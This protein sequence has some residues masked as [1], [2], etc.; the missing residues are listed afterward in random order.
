MMNKLVFRN[1]KRSAKDYMVYFITMTVVTALMFSFNTLLFS[2]DIQK[3]FEMGADIMPIMIGLATFF[4]I[5]IVAWLINYMVRFT[6]EKRSREFGIYLLIGM[7]KKEISRLYIRENL[8]LG[9]GAFIIGM[10]SGFLLQQILLSIFYSMVQMDYHLHLEFNKNCILMTAACYGGCYLLALLRCRKRFKKMNIHDLMVSQ[11]Q[12]EEIKEKHE[13]GKQR[14]FPIS[15]VFLISFGIFLFRCKNWDTGTVVVF[16]IGLVLTVYLFYTGIAAWISGYVRRKGNA[17]YRGNNLFLL[18]QFASKVRTMSVTMGTL[19]ALFMLALLGSSVAFMFNYFQNQVLINKFPFDVQVNSSNVNEDFHKEIALL[20]Q[21]IQVNEIY[22]Y[23]IYE[24]GTNQVNAWLYT[25]LKEFG[26]DYQKADGTPDWEE[27]NRN[28]QMVYCD[29]DTYM[30]LS[31]YNHLRKMLGL[32]E[33][34]LQGD[35]YAIHIKNRVLNQT[36]DFSDQIEV[37]GANGYLSFAGYYTESFSQDG[38]NGGDYI[39][40]V[41]DAAMKGMRPYYAELVADIEGKAPA[42]L[43]NQLDDIEEDSKKINSQGHVMTE[44]ASDDWD[45]EKQGNSCSG[46]DTIVVYVAKN[47]VRDN[48]IPEVKYMLS[49]IIFPMFYVGMVFL[50]VALT[51]LSVQQLS[52]SVK[53]RF[54]YR[55][56]SQIG[57]SRKE[58]GRIILKQL[59]GY[60]MCPALM[61]LVISGLIAVCVGKRFNFY[62][63][64]RITSA[65]YFLIS[66]ALFF[67][68]Y[69]V[70]FIVTY[71]GFKRNVERE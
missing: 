50:C 5:L 59:F 28:E 37:E 57:Y 39:L 7:K 22:K 67:S 69:T 24:N 71:I 6:L 21:E 51:V 42:D 49:S 30:R 54:R 4:I 48:L 53:Y 55:V 12:N 64:V 11:N 9:T 29:Y 32:P 15:V 31:D 1:V 56:L 20:N 52:D 68:I 19:T 2:K 10:G 13:K 45:G 61:A 65:V 27:I 66:V 70:Y 63:G 25:H 40:I 58:I 14:L 26:A 47:L 33:I 18:R 3:M 34:T 8:L 17:V 38:H 23:Q 35:E 62:T 60:Y 44:A 43:Q 41:P 46:S 16:L 36:G